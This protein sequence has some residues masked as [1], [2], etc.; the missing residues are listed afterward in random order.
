MGAPVASIGSQW[1]G[2]GGGILGW[3]LATD[4]GRQEWRERVTSAADALCIRKLEC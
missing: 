2:S 4:Y 3:S 1:E